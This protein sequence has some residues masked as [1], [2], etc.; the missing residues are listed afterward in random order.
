MSE[1]KIPPCPKCG[2][3]LHL[4]EKGVWGCVSDRGCDRLWYRDKGEL[5]EIEPETLNKGA[6]GI[7]KA[8]VPFPATGSATCP[9]GKTVITKNP[10]DGWNM[11][12]RVRVPK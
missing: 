5:A 4:V 12:S 7:C 9:C 3:S 6:C 11:K 2:R 1:F 8:E 10:G